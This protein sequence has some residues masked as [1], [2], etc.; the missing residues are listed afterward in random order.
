MLN[1]EIISCLSD[2]YSYLL[3][4]K[5]LNI[6]G[7]IDPSDFDT[8]CYVK[9]GQEQTCHLLSYQSEIAFLMVLGD[10]LNLRYEPVQAQGWG[11]DQRFTNDSWCD[12]MN[13]SCASIRQTR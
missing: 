10:D 1:I 5:E 13:A 8:Y 2:N 9:N 6:V 4:D 11:D 12:L 7:I 3:E